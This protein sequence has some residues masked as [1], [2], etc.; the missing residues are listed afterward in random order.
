MS[1]WASRDKFYG[2]GMSARIAFGAVLAV[3]AFPFALTAFIT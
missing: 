3:L 2:E 1:G